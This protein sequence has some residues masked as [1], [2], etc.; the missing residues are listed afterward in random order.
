M[1]LD[2][3]TGKNPCV[4]GKGSFKCNFGP[5]VEEERKEIE[6]YIDVHM[7]VLCTLK[8]KLEDQMS[9]GFNCPYFFN[10]KHNCV[11]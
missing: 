8:D 7:H 1:K 10:L 6:H 11:S 3:I 2:V 4:H 9:L 5:T